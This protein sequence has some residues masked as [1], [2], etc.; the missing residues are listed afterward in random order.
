MDA[1][2]VLRREHTRIEQLFVEFDGLSQRA[3]T[4]R[5]ALIRELDELVRRHIEMEEAFVYQGA[6]EAPEDHRLVVRMLDEIAQTECHTPAYVPRVHTLRD[7]LLR[8]MKDEE[9]HVFPAYA[10]YPQVA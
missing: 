2:T 9:A 5:R 8:H 1:L 6:A 3:C 4:G 10:G 7:V